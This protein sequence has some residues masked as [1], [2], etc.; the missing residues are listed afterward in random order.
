MCLL[1]CKNKF[2]KAY[3]G[4]KGNTTSLLRRMV[5]SYIRKVSGLRGTVED[6]LELRGGEGA[7][8]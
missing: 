7:L 2:M 8:F 1:D 4:G 3:V 5:D 6:A